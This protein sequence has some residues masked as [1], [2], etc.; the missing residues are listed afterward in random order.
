MKKETRTKLIS[1]LC[2][3][4]GL[5][6]LFFIWWLVSFCLHQNNNYIL[7]YPSETFATLGQVL[8]SFES[9][10]YTWTAIG[11]T[12]L[13]LLIG[14]AISFILGAI[15]GT[16]GGLYKGV[17]S[18]MS[19]YVVF[20][21]AMPTAAFVLILVGMF[22][23]VNYLAT[24]IPCF[25]VFLVA[26]PVIYEA[27]RSGIKNE[28]KDTLDALELDSGRKSFQSVIHVLWPDSLSYILL[29]ITQSL[30]LSMK[31]SVMSEILVNSSS[32]KGGLGGLI[33]NAAYNLSMKDVIAYSLIAVFLILLID[34]P[35]SLLK[36]E[37]KTGLS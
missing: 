27:F 33:Q 4:G 5:V 29:S 36:K 25:L 24:Y 8:F 2:L 26:F 21:K 12:L 6:F 10:A 37:I 28:D 7:P 14:F 9:S 18:F 16:L 17:S 30:G 22:Y 19:P 15:L 23:R 11:W 13:R 32:A 20:S 34:I 1:S 35:M 31:V 3:L